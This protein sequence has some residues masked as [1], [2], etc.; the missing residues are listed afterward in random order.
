[1]KSK[2]EHDL[3]YY[4]EAV[5]T[6]LRELS[7]LKFQQASVQEKVEFLSDRFKKQIKEFLETVAAGP[8]RPMESAPKDGRCILVEFKDGERYVC[9]WSCRD[10]G[11]LLNGSH[12]KVVEVVEDEPTAWAELR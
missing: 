7:A 10:N 1:M 2:T 11:W 5:Y 12:H 6:A 3:D 9:Y 8:W 4:Q